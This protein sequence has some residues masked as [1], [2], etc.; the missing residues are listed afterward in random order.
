MARSSHSRSGPS[1]KDL[2]ARPRRPKPLQ[3]TTRAQASKTR[4]RS[5]TGTWSWEAPRSSSTWRA[6]SPPPYSYQARQA[7]RK[8]PPPSTIRR[9]CS[10]LLQSHNNS[11]KKRLRW[12]NLWRWPLFLAKRASIQSLRS[13]TSARMTK[14]KTKNKCLFLAEIRLKS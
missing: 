11:K 3:S 14:K 1:T 7:R 5:S 12:R 6:A 13:Q 2:S 4:C 8:S 10:R 9:S